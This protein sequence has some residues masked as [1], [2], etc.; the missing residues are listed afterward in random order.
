MKKIIGILLI[1]TGLLF[2]GPVQ[3]QTVYSYS[4]TTITSTASDGTAYLTYPSKLK[5]NYVGYL[6]VNAD[7][8]SYTD[9]TLLIHQAQISID[10]STWFDYG[11]ADTLIKYADVAEKDEDYLI[12]STPYLYRREKFTQ[13]DTA[14]TVLTGKI[15]FKQQ[16]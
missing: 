7:T 15:T 13:S 8:T 11:A 1:I 3:A 12:T 9:S 14:T 10:N 6:T 4:T 16:N 2:Y 5:L